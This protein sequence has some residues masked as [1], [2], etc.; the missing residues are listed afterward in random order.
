MPKKDTAAAVAAMLSTAGAQTRRIPERIEPT[1][2]AP[3]A[4]AITAVTVTEPAP[5]TITTLPPPVAPAPAPIAEAPRTLRLQPTTAQRLRD[6]W[7]EAKRDDVLLTAQDFA[8]ALVD[9]ALSRRG[10]S[11]VINR[12]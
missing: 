2:P 10:R 7:L 12:G 8:S 11:R 4:P 1:A 3:A 9:E 5:A 6:A